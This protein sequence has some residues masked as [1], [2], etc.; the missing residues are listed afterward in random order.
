[1]A[2]YSNIF[3]N[4]LCFVYFLQEQADFTKDDEK[5]HTT[6]IHSVNIFFATQTGTAQ[7]NVN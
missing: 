3:Y 5:P 1:M 4:L 7:V 2:F 6:A